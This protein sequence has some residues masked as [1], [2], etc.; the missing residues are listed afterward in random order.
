MRILILSLVR[1]KVEEAT[2]TVDLA[3]QRCK[4]HKE[5]YEGRAAPVVGC[6]RMAAS[7]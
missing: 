7:T 3:G 6:Q 2:E 5:T 1:Q 4:A